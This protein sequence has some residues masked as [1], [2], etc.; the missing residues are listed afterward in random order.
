MFS[1]ALDDKSLAINNKKLIE[2]I[3]DLLQLEKK[4]RVMVISSREK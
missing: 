4:R 1:P 3:K 2:R